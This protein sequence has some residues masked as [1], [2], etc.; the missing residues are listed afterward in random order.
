MFTRQLG[1]IQ[2]KSNY[3]SKYESNKRYSSINKLINQNLEIS[4]AINPVVQNDQYNLNEDE[5]FVKQ[6][7]LDTSEYKDGELRTELIKLYKSQKKHK[8]VIDLLKDQIRKFRLSEE[9]YKM[10]AEQQENKLKQQRVAYE[11]KILTIFDEKNQENSEQ[12]KAEISTQINLE[13]KI[14]DLNQ[15]VYN[16]KQQIEQ[17][18]QE[19]QKFKIDKINL[20]KQMETNQ[21]KVDHAMSETQ[22]KFKSKEGN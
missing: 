21:S 3:N 19:T 16:L 20:Q 6:I 12:Q 22:S 1:E 5:D 9:Q 13:S 11:K 2:Y 17:K 14:R 7:D 18:E 4:K 10:N 15:E 8:Q